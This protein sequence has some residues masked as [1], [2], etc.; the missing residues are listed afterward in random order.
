[1]G[2]G[3]DR[4]CQRKTHEGNCETSLVKLRAAGHLK[5]AEPA[6]RGGSPDETGTSL[7]CLL[8]AGQQRRE[9]STLREEAYRTCLY[10]Y[11]IASNNR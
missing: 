7:T 3:A 4:T 8:S 11:L 6:E 10:P 9:C 1:M 5:T 2:L